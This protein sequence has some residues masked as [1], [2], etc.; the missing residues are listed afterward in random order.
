MWHLAFR[1]LGALLLGG[2]VAMSSTVVAGE[3]PC[4]P[5]PDGSSAFWLPMTY[6]TIAS[7]K[8][9][10]IVAE[11]QIKANE[12]QR[13]RAQIQAATSRPGGIN[14]IWFN[15]P[16]GLSEEGQKM[17]RVIRGLGV[18]TRIRNGSYCVSAC[19]VAFLGGV[20]RTVEPGGV[21]TVHMFSNFSGLSAD[22][23]LKNTVRDLQG[24]EQESA[25]YAAERYQY[26][27]E[28][29]ISP[30]VAKHGFS[31]QNRGESCPPRPVLREWNVD[32]GS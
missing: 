16:G 22:Q 19:S 20:F 24:L 30:N 5:W 12:S 15:S 1:R 32:N 17:G 4:P 3:Y 25:Q 27:L 23:N 9:V 28:M 21:Y 29:G 11:G 14:E 8:G 6:H 31:V 2:W 7:P 18:P 13:L 10:V 26:L